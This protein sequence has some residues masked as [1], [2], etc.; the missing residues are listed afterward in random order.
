MY[1]DDLQDV[2]RTKIFDGR[3]RI[4][5]ISC[6]G[7][8]KSGNGG[9]FT[10]VWT[11]ISGKIYCSDCKNYCIRRDFAGKNLWYELPQSQIGA[12]ET[13]RFRGK[14][15]RVYLSFC[16]ASYGCF[17]HTYPHPS[18]HG[19]ALQKRISQPQIQRNAWDHAAVYFLLWL[20]LITCGC[21]H[22]SWQKKI[23][24]RWESDQN[25]FTEIK[26]TTYKKERKQILYPGL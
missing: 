4:L 11:W 23:S 9:R 20:V 16:T 3:R 7:S 15:F 19:R 8:L 17:S 5:Y 25:T 24:R 18:G 22:S 13:L 12:A 6:S 26:T 21:Y 10:C 1:W 14:S 2:W